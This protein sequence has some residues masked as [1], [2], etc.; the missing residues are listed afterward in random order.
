MAA[1]ACTAAPQQV[2]HKVVVLAA[3]P[4][5]TRCDEQRRFATWGFGI[6]VSAVVQQQLHHLQVPLLCCNRER[7]AAVLAGLIHVCAC[8]DHRP[9]H[10]RVALLAANV[11]CRSAFVVDIAVITW[12][13]RDCCSSG[14]SCGHGRTHRRCAPM[15]TAPALLTAV[16]QCSPAMAQAPDRCVHK[17]KRCNLHAQAV[18]V[19]SMR[20]EVA[21]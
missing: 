8:R 5:G 11:Q 16:L 7:R 15:N 9:R 4:P 12:R 20:Q 14:K 2:D 21:V 18:H 17:R 3:A 13:S 10:G 1:S 19:A 6:C